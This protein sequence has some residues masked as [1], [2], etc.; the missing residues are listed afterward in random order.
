MRV[1]PPK[2]SIPP[3]SRGYGHLERISS[4]R[5]SITT[6]N[7]SGIPRYRGRQTTGQRYAESRR[8]YVPHNRQMR[9]E[10]RRI[11]QK[12]LRELE[13]EIEQWGEEMNVRILTS[14][15]N[16]LRERLLYIN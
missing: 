9:V 6:I 7:E 3:S 10:L 16:S 13:E 11:Y 1:I 8:D 5:A 12:R 4:L 2:G 15:A 14:E